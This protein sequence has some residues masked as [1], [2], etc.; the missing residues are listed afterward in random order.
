MCDRGG[1]AAAATGR[2]FGEGLAFVPMG[3]L[4]VVAATAVAFT[5]VANSLRPAAVGSL[6]AT[7]LVGGGLYLAWVEA[8]RPR[9]A[10]HAV[11]L[12]EAEISEEDVPGG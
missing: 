7:A 8:G 12:A 5:L 4:N 2:A 11:A 10:S 1:A 9:G 3:A 6:A